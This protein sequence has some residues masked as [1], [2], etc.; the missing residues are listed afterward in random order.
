[1]TGIGQ[2]RSPLSSLQVCE[3]E[4]SRL[5]RLR[6]REG[7]Q[8]GGR[9][10]FLLLKD[11]RCY[12]R[13]KRKR[14]EAAVAR[15]HSPP[16]SIAFNISPMH[17]MGG[18]KKK[19]NLLSKTG[20]KKSAID[21]NLAPITSSNKRGEKNLSAIIDFHEDSSKTS[22][23]GISFLPCGMG[24]KKKPVRPASFKEGRKRH[25]RGG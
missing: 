8:G 1:M 19:G 6:I 20:N 21:E 14:R 12:N 10:F 15:T 25:Q 23:N 5:P 17:T 13:E 11:G 9:V 2:L 24:G 7:A 16:W 18:K 3:E 4:K 22:V